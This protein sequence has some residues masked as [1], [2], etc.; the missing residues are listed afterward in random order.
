MDTANVQ[1]YMEEIPLKRTE[2]LVEYLL[3]N[4]G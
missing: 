4:K 3:H 2:E 1:V